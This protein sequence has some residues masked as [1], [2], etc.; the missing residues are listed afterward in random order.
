MR[1]PADPINVHRCNAAQDLHLFYQTG[2]DGRQNPVIEML[3]SDVI[4]INV[5][6]TLLGLMQPG[7]NELSTHGQ[8]KSTYSRSNTLHE[9]LVSCI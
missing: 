4:E 2:A 8:E 7:E 3:L 9:V 1:D 5:S 6:G